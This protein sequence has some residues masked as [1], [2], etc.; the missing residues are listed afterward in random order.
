MLTRFAPPEL[1]GWIAPSTAATLFVAASLLVPVR[2]GATGAGR[3]LEVS[4][5]AEKLAAQIEALKEEQIIDQAKA[6]SLEA[7]GTADSGQLS[8]RLSSSST[9]APMRARTSTAVGSGARP[10]IH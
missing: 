1:L 5:E 9:A 3:T 6:E 10:W 2:F 7:I 8:E 4:K